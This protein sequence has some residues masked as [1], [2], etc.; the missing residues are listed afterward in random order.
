[1]VKYF[2]GVNLGLLFLIKLTHTTKTFSLIFTPNTL[3]R[4]MDRHFQ[5]QLANTE[6]CTLFK[7]TQS[8]LTALRIVIDH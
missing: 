8:T 7:N 3:Q 4:G 1:L 5:T 6:T 2:I